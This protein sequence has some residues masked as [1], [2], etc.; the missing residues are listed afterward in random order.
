MS[1]TN[2]PEVSLRGNDEDN[3]L[4]G[5]DKIL[6]Q[7]PS[8]E[9][10]VKMINISEL[11]HAC[12][13]L[14]DVTTI[15]PYD[16]DNRPMAASVSPESEPRAWRLTNQKL[17]TTTSVFAALRQKSGRAISSANAHR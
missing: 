6:V 12:L 1:E 5:V 16:A 13:S 8:V 4:Y 11:D 17:T 9:T 15:T 10:G 7:T 2:E 3:L 14:E